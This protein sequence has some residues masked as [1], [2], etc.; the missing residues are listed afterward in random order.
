MAAYINKS[1]MPARLTRTRRSP[2]VPRTRSFGEQSAGDRADHPQAPGRFA[3]KECDE[4]RGAGARPGGDNA[5]GGDF[6]LPG[7][8]RSATPV[9][10]LQVLAE[11]GHDLDEVA[12]HVAVVELRLDDA[13]P[14]VPAGARRAGQHEHEG[15]VEHA[16]GRPRLTAEVPI[17]SYEMRWKTSEKPSMRFSKIGSSASGVTSRPVKPVPPVVMTTSISTF[18]H[19]ATHSRMRSCRRSRCGARRACGL[20]Q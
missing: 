10:A 5:V 14:G 2:A 17:L 16:P 13:V 15:R 20:L 8:D 11:P 3:R 19:A 1:V 7:G 9:A 12:G 18:D 4:R 6:T